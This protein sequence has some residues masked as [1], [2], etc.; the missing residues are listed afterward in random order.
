MSLPKKHTVKWA[1]LL[2]LGDENI[3]WALQNEAVILKRCQSSC[4]AACLHFTQALSSFSAALA[5]VP[6]LLFP[7]LPKASL[8]ELGENLPFVVLEQG[9]FPTFQLLF[10]WGARER[11][12]GR[13]RV[14]IV[15][16]SSQNV[17]VFPKRSIPSLKWVATLQA[18]PAL[19]WLS[20]LPLSWESPWEIL[21][22]FQLWSP[23]QEAS[24]ELLQGHSGLGMCL[25]YLLLPKNLKTSWLLFWLWFSASESI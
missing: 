23:C 18:L 21:Q 15:W 11:G 9:L 25:S 22:W 2:F 13:S 3:L 12:R 16:L 17:R 20:D 24:G 7:A 4:W 5:S 6:F 1:A 19:K 14:T 8:P 10:S